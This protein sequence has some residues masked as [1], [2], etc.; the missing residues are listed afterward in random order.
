MRALSK[1]DLHLALETCAAAT[2]EREY[3]V[4][5]AVAIVGPCAEP[6][7]SLVMSAEIDLFPRARESAER[8]ALTAGVLPQSAA[9]RA[10]HSSTTSFLR[11]YPAYAA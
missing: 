1:A 7:P 3:I 2:G 11:C 4:V 10:D 9:M 6:P 8:F 5:G